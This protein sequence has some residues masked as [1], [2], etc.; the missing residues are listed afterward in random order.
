MPEAD[1]GAD[2]PDEFAGEAPLADESRDSALQYVAADILEA[3]GDAEAQEELLQP[4]E[5]EIRAHYETAVRDGIDVAFRTDPETGAEKAINTLRD[6]LTFED[7]PE[8]HRSEV[9]EAV[10]QR[11]SEKQEQLAERYWEAMD[12]AKHEAVRDGKRDLLDWGA[13]V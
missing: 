5:E 4:V 10:E 11:L 1:T 13:V 6:R 3:G 2:I 8:P 12:D 7:V 9:R